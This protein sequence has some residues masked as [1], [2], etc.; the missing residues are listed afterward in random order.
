MCALSRSQNSSPIRQIDPLGQ[1][2]GR[3]LSIQFD[4]ERN[5]QS[6]FLYERDF[7]SVQISQNIKNSNTLLYEQWKY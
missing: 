7:A 4:G 5:L 3:A 6:F 1:G 2:C